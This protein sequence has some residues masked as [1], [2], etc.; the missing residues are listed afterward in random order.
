M[1]LKATRA[2]NHSA[3]LSAKAGN[4]QLAPKAAGCD[5]FHVILDQ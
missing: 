4:W 2:G 1:L 5:V 3:A